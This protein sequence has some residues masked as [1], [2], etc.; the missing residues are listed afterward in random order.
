MDMDPGKIWKHLEWLAA[1]PRFAES[2]RLEECR[3]YC[4]IELTAAGWTVER[5]PFEASDSMLNTLNGINLVARRKK[6]ADKSQKATQKPVFILGAHLDS[7]ED[8]P[9]ADDNAS[10]VAVLL[11][12]ARIIDQRLTAKDWDSTVVDLEL[13][14]FDL[15]EHGMLGA[16]SHAAS[17]RQNQRLVSGMVSLEMLGYCSHE[18]G[19]QRFPQQLEGLYSDVGNFIG[20]V[21]N[22]NSTALINHFA[23]AFKSVADLPSQLLQVPNSGHTLPATRLSDHSPYW[24]EGFAALMITD[25]SFLRN[26][27][28]H[29]PTDTPET[30]DRVFLHKVSQGVLTATEGI[31]RRGLE[32]CL[33]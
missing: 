2:D 16:A 20:V 23:A 31:V 28:Y 4:E 6:T 32:P 27:H 19:S 7:C 1:V 13:V 22:Q 8:T 3:Q 10:A 12:T 14:V 33:K 9:G 18:P 5:Q 11:E 24:D 15:E 26:P 25:T 17:C 30:L 21:G 29:Q